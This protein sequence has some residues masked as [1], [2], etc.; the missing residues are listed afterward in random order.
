MQTN[1]PAWLHPVAEH[2]KI[3]RPVGLAHG[4]KHFD[5]N[6]VIKAPGGVAVVFEPQFNP[7][8]NAR[9]FNAAPGPSQLLT[10]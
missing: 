9:L 7:I 1:M 4:F 10:R 6:G 5:R 3:D 8:A 2:L